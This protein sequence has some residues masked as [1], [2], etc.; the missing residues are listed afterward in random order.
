[1]LYKQWK[2]WGDLSNKDVLDKFGTALAGMGISTG[3]LP[4]L[5]VATGVIV[6]HLTVKTFCE[7]YSTEGE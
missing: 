3:L 4:T 5:A 2:R 6:L 7:E 1:M